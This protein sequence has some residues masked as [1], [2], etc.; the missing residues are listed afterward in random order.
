M[1]QQHPNKPDNPPALPF[2][3]LKAWWEENGKIAP[4]E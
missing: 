2:E 3:S 4:E 1:G